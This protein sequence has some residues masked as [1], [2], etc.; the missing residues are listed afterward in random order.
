MPKSA[1]KFRPA[2]NPVTPIASSSLCVFQGSLDVTS[3]S[4]DHL[5]V[6]NVS[7]QTDVMPCQPSLDLRED[8]NGRLGAAY[9]SSYHLATF[10]EWRPNYCDCRATERRTNPQNRR[11]LVALSEIISNNFI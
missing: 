10:D 9:P 5:P 11:R 3:S 1:E 4:T 8:K 2:E 6:K 7:S